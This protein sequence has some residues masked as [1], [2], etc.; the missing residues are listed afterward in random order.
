MHIENEF[1]EASDK[2]LSFL[3]IWQALALKQNSTNL[4]YMKIILWELKH[5]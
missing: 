1:Y 3:S 4:L 5:E 2:F